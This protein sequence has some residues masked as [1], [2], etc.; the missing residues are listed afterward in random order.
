MGKTDVLFIKQRIRRGPAIESSIEDYI[1]K[2]FRVHPGINFQ[3][4]ELGE[5][6][7]IAEDRVTAGGQVTQQSIAR[8]RYEQTELCLGYIRQQAPENL[9]LLNGYLLWHF[10]QQFYEKLR[11]L[12][13]KISAWQLDDPYYV[14]MSL[15]FLHL[16]DTIFTVDTITL[17]LYERYELNAHWL[18]LACAPEVHRSINDLDEKY[19]SDVCFIGVPFKGSK[20]VRTIDAIAGKLTVCN[21]RIIGATDKENWT[22]VLANADQL[23]GS[24]MD[25][26]VTVEEACLYYNGAAINLNLHKDSYGHAWDRNAHRLPARSPCERTFAIAGCGGFQIMDNDRPDLAQLFTTNED[27]VTFKDPADLAAKIDYYLAH[28]DERQQMARSLQ[29]NV[30]I[31]HSYA[32][33][34][35]RI[36][37]LA[38]DTSA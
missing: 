7:R 21:S 11:P 26:F 2:A 10:D 35:N 30:H 13:R 3:C 20:R 24:L 27:I 36:V 34:A 29:R 38:F 32:A 6:I 4:Y 31:G 28:D 23:S 5:K 18:P 25:E 17:P 14:D 37:E 33:R 12:V 22:G 1:E 16:L 19:R 8:A 9:F 15:P